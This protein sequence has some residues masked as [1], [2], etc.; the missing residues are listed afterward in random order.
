MA[1]IIIFC[2]VIPIL[3]SLDFVVAILR[4]ILLIECNAVRAEFGLKLQCSTHLFFL[5]RAAPPVSI[6]RR[7]EKPSSPDFDPG[8]ALGK[9]RG[10]LFA[11]LFF[12]CPTS[13]R[14]NSFSDNADETIFSRPTD[15]CVG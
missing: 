12:F 4:G 2:L 3:F 1:L 14:H 9:Q 10:P 15:C 7:I 11:D 6:D 13:D 8:R 5:I